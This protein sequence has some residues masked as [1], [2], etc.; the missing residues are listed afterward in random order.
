MQTR[1]LLQE[2]GRAYDGSASGAAYV[3]ADPIGLD[4]GLNLYSYANQNP[5]MFTDPDGLYPRIGE[6]GG[7][8]RAGPTCGP[9]K[10]PPAEMRK[11]V[12]CVSDCFDNNVKDA[13][14]CTGLPKKAKAICLAAYAAGRII[15]TTKCSVK[16]PNC[17]RET[18]D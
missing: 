2:N 16:Y 9:D 6:G 7:G 13:T 1:E 11:Y 18:L 15:C 4:G 17:W 10:C 12:K 5:V 8:W 3:Q 14:V